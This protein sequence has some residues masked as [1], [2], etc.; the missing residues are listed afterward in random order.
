MSP[1]DIGKIKSLLD[2]LVMKKG[3]DDREWKSSI[4]GMYMRT[5]FGYTALYEI[6]VSSSKRKMKSLETVNKLRM[7]QQGLFG[8]YRTLSQ[9]KYKK[10]PPTTRI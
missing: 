10:Q 8:E 3:E 5:W 4:S 1:K 7:E 9:K 6:G 2:N